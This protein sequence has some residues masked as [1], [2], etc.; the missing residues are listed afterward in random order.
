ML[1]E[2]NCFK[3]LENFILKWVASWV[4]NLIYLKFLW[5]CFP[6]LPDFLDCVWFKTFRWKLDDRTFWKYCLPKMLYRQKLNDLILFYFL[7]YLLIFFDK[8]SKWKIGEG[9]ID[10][11]VFYF[12]LFS[13]WNRNTTIHIPGIGQ[14]F[15]A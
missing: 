3:N 2:E 9:K 5:F 7:N 6:L 14:L 13:D 11:L 10:S 15:R 1:R 12:F 8:Y 4:L